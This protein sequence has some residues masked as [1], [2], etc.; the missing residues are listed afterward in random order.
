[1]PT[2]KIL[3]LKKGEELIS[4]IIAFCKVN[5]ID[6][7]WFTGL[8]AAEKAILALYDLKTKKYSKKEISEP[9][10]IANIIG[11]IAMKDNDIAVHCHII[12]S[13][14]EMIAFAG[15]VESVT[16]GATCEIIFRILDI[17]LKRKHDEEI[18]L[19]LLEI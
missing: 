16:I 14:K 6:S 12:L 7:A 1:M 15:H 17:P 19:N 5:Q 2:N 3:R 9:L 10:E 18:G 4:G 8:G 11:N 13:N